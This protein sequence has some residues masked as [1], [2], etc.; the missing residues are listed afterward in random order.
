[1]TASLKS[2]RT[3]KLENYNNNDWNY[4]DDNNNDHSKYYDVHIWTGLY[5]ALDDQLGIEHD[6]CMFTVNSDWSW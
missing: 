3:S 6:A 1:M 5:I 2:V 4:L